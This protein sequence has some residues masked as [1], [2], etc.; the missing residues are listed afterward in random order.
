M[1]SP[2]PALGIDHGDVRV[3][4][5]ATDAAGILA[6]PVETIDRRRVDPFERIAAICSERRV[7]TLV[8][9]LPVR[10]DGSEGSNAGRVRLFAGELAAR[11]PGLPVEFVDETFT[12]TTAADKLRAAGR[13]TKDQRPVIDQA[14]AIEILHQWMET[15]PPADEPET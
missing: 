14:A 5:A 13:K 11:L 9:G 4:L 1:N 8:I 6:H 3:G 2:H 15:L 10:L 7:R 12:T